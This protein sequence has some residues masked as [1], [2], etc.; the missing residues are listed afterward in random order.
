MQAI[1]LK[2]NLSYHTGL[3]MSPY[4]ATFGMKPRVGLSDYFPPA[5][6]DE[7]RIYNEEEIEKLLN[8]KSDS[9]QEEHS[10]SDDEPSLGLSAA[11]TYYIFRVF[12][13]I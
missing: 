12:N 10:Q 5:F 8:D 2:K 7:K 1:Q 13:Q 11:I 4:E 6:L 3:G 9:T